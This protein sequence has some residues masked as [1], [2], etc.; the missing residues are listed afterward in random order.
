MAEGT[1]QVFFTCPAPV[2]L[3]C[4]PALCVARSENACVLVVKC[5]HHPTMMGALSDTCLLTQLQVVICFNW[6]CWPG[7]N[8][9]QQAVPLAGVCICNRTP[10]PRIHHGQDR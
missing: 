9:E 2:K 10:R 1:L 4:A 3:I 5:G 8:V 6:V 7:V